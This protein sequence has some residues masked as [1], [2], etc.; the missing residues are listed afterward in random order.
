MANLVETP[1]FSDDLRR[2]GSLLWR[3]SWLIMLSMVLAGGV[4]FLVSQQTTP[5]YQAKATVLVEQPNTLKT[6]VYNDVIKDERSIRTYT[7]M[8]VK[9]PVLDGVLEALD[10][11]G[12]LSRQ[13]LRHMVQVNLLRDTELIEVIVEDTDPERAAAIANTI[14]TEFSQQIQSLQAERYSESK[15]NLESQMAALQ[16][17]LDQVAARLEEQ[18]EPAEKDRLET[19]QAQYRE[20]YAYLLQGYEEIRIIESQSTSNV[21]ALEEAEIPTNPIR[22]KVLQNTL[23]AAI[24]G[25]MLAVGLVF[26]I[27]AL[28]DTLRKPE[29]FEAI[30]LPV[31]GVISQTEQESSE[32]IVAISDPRS[33]VTEAYRSLRTNIQ[34]ASIDHPIK[35]LLVT[36]P[37]PNDGKTTIVCNLAAV[38]AQGEQKV[39]AIDSDL[40]KPALHRM[41]QI[42]NRR[43]LSEVCIQNP[44]NLNGHLQNT[45]LSNLWVL[46]SGNLPPN[47]AELLNSQKMNLVI[48]QAK[49]KTDFVI[50]D[51]PPVLAVTDACVLA[52]RVDGV[53]LVVRAGK[54]KKTLLQETI[55]RLK[56]VNANLLGVVVNGVNL[57]RSSYYYRTYYPYYGNTKEGR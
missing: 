42:A 8:M 10:L 48:Q 36:S 13:D 21:I 28:D 29:D 51:S 27:D 25:G 2:Y 43:G 30:G 31:L 44:V 35:T 20:M 38:T 32:P 22:P 26:L 49:E 5:V 46:P 11:D 24:V 34:Y 57:K 1:S 6:S 15:S 7:E 19:L 53:L 18:P 33:L 52:S 12:V 41:L 23:L 9:A 50:M 55:K 37:L 56:H 14:V 40:R 16:V 54:A 4:A 39:A 17:E 3:W 47:P 45:S